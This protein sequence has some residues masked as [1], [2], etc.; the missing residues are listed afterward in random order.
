MFLQLHRPILCHWS[1]SINIVTTSENHVF[2]EAVRRQRKEHVALS[3]L[4][5]FRPL[6]QTEA[7]DK[8]RHT[9]REK[10]PYSEFF[11][12][13][14]S[15]IRTEYGK[16][17]SISPCSVRMRENTDQ[18]NSEYGHFS[19]NESQYNFNLLNASVAFV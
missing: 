14:F 17:R 10:C 7:L 12:S 15:R 16:T 4:M 2:P 8:F 1:L 13:V 18:K 11:W 5:T 19:R 3:G 9:L 6:T